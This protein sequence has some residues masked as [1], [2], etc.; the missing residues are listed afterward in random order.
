MNSDLIAR[1]NQTWCDHFKLPLEIASRPGTTLFK[2]DLRSEDG[3]I[4]LWPVGEHIVLEI[5]PAVEAIIQ[6]FLD[7]FPADHRITLDDFKR[8]W[9]EIEIEIMPLY[10]MDPAAFRPF[11]VSPPYTL[12]Q[13][14]TD[15]QPAFDAFLAQCSEED[16]DEGDISL[17]YMITFGVFDGAR[18]VA[19]A[20][21]Y[22]WRGFIDIGIL[23]DPAYRK[24]GFGKALV[25]ACT[26]YYLAGDK[27]V[28]Y[29]HD[30]NNIG[31]RGIAEGLNFSYYADAEM[32]KMPAK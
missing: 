19:G 30:V 8:L 24:K 27:V 26:E 31:S 28:G 10:A 2:N 23:T 13:L 25:S 4:A 32:L 6:S 14:T 15:D 12:R 1:V 9:G 20:S 11:S 5:A 16:K 21:V 18:I 17:E 22:V 7:G 3:Y 29:R